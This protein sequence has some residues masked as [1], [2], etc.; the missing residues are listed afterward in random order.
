MGS[1]DGRVVN[2]FD[3][4]NDLMWVMWSRLRGPGLG[5]AQIHWKNMGSVDFSQFDVI[6]VYQW[7]LHMERFEEKLKRE[8]KPGAHLRSQMRFEEWPEELADE[9]HGLF[10]YKQS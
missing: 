9:G 6:F 1:G 10:V 4:N 3:H 5:P 8:L 7:D 2:G